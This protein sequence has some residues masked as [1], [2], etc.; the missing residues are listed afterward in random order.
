VRLGHVASAVLFGAATLV[1]VLLWK[2][3]GLLREARL[4][5][6]RRRAGRP[7]TGG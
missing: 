5:E 2:S 4:A 7:R 6:L 1:G 3:A